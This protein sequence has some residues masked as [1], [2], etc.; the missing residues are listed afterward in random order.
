MDEKLFTI[1]DIDEGFK[2]LNI[3]TFHSDKSSSIASLTLTTVDLNLHQHS[4][5]I[6]HSLRK[7]N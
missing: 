2:N 6:I 5:L 4:T 7:H 1:Q 3:Q